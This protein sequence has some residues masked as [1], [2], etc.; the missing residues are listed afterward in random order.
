MRKIIRSIV[1]WVA[2]LACS[3]ALGVVIGLALVR[4]PKPPHTFEMNGIAITLPGDFKQERD[5]SITCEG[6]FYNSDAEIVFIR[7][8]AA[9]SR[10][11][12]LEEYVESVRESNG[13]DKALQAENGMRYFSYTGN[14]EKPMQYYLVIL[15]G[16]DAF[17]M[18]RVALWQKDAENLFP[19][20]FQWM[21]TVRF[22]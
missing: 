15:E 8:I 7:D 6:T 13:Y 5:N 4:I 10:S 16:E 11:L 3:I 9:F 2:V 14:A 22:E 12:S 1:T 17:W 20:V 18:V 19:K 21:D